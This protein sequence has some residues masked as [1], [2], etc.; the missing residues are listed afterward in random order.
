EALDERCGPIPNI[1]TQL[2]NVLAFEPEGHYSL[3]FL[4]G[5]LMYLNESDV[6]ALLQ[7]LR[8]Y[9]GPKGVILCRESTVRGESEARVGDYPVIYRTVADY[10]RIFR[11][12]GL[13][14]NQVERNEPYVLMQMGCELIKKWKRAM[15]K[16]VQALPV[17]GHLT[18]WSL[19]LGAR[20]IK[21]IPKALSI[22]FPYLENHFFVARSRTECS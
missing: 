9:L 14:L 19:R 17:V 8:P 5:L 6:I 13:T 10:K 18:Y 16:P 21:P 4:G 20:W 12:S 1:R 7:K 22:P 2:G 11:Q 3:V 15:P